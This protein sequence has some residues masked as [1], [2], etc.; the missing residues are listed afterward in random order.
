VTSEP[1]QLVAQGS[2]EWKRKLPLLSGDKCAATPGGARGRRR[3]DDMTG[4]GSLQ[5]CE[6]VISSCLFALGR[7]AAW[8]SNCSVWPTTCCHVAL[9]PS[10]IN[11]ITLEDLVPPGPHPKPQ[12]EVAERR[13]SEPRSQPR[14]QSQLQRDH[15]HHQSMASGKPPGRYRR[16]RKAFDLPIISAAFPPPSKRVH[17]RHSQF[18]ELLIFFRDV[19]IEFF[20][21]Y[22]II[23][24]FK[25]FFPSNYPQSVNFRVFPF[26]FLD[27]LSHQTVI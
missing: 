10:Y 22:Q 12:P 11:L 5:S 21:I 2:W 1:R 27:F 24:P 9:P 13:T 6:D 7:W 19:F 4:G 18:F 8:P 14:A 16:L 15:S 3:R 20:K 23:H 17:L 25:Y 26:L